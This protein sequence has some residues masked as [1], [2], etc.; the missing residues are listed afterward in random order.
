MEDDTETA[1]P[2]D[3]L[4]GIFGRLPPHTLAACRC[5]CKAWRALID[6]RGLLLPH[7]LPHALRG[8]FINYIDY[9]RPGL[10]FARPSASTR[11][12]IINGN[13]LLGYLPAS[14]SSDISVLDHCNGLLLYGGARELY[15]VNP[16]TR[17]WERLPPLPADASEY[18]A[19]LVFDPAVSLHYEV[20]LIPRVPHKK[21]RRFRLKKKDKK[22]RR[23][24]LKDDTAPATSFNRSWCFSTMDNSASCAEVSTEMEHSEE[25][26]KFSP[27]SLQV[28]EEAVLYPTRQASS[29]SSSWEG[30]FDDP[31]R[32]MEW[33]PPSCTVQVFSSVTKRWEQRSFVREGEAVGTVEDVIHD[34]PKVQSDC[35]TNRH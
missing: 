2:D 11:H 30:H 13:D 35:Y 28:M 22:S 6:A 26:A 14:T 16:A 32:L 8:I 23:W 10:F 27:S 20:F 29:S 34:K 4:A 5:V 31:Y 9:P 19:Y 3:A 17:Q 1:V 7:A 25:Q 24:Y 12:G 18:L 21:S 15:V 33:P